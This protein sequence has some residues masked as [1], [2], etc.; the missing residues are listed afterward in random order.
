MNLI[1]NHTNIIDLICTFNPET[2]DTQFNNDRG[3]EVARF[4]LLCYV[5]A[6]THKNGGIK[7]VN[8][9]IKVGCMR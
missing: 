2:R 6:T 3:K 9:R 8:N 5:E 4:K 1:I 7:D